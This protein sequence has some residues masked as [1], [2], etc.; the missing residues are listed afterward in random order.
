MR[1]VSDILGLL[2]FIGVC[3]WGGLVVMASPQDKP[4]VACRPVL[5]VM[6]GARDVVLAAGPNAPVERALG[7]ANSTLARA[8]LA[9]AGNLFEVVG[10]P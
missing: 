5:A 9:Y 4:R 7:T 3:L 10:R 8:C 2:L 6:H 1:A